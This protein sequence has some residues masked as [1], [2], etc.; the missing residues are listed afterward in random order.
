MTTEI[1]YRLAPLGYI[2]PKQCIRYTNQRARKQLMENSSKNII[3]R[4]RSKGNDENIYIVKHF[5]CNLRIGI[6]G[7]EVC[8]STRDTFET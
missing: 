7:T 2:L 4:F 5:S 1:L 3:S 8:R 6:M